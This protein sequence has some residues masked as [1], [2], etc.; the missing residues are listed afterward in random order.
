[1]NRENRAVR[2]LSLFRMLGATA[3]AMAAGVLAVATGTGGRS[4]VELQPGDRAPDFELQGS[5]G[6]VYR[7][8]GIVGPQGTGHAVVIAWFP[9]AFT[10]G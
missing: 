3:A 4:D 6:R 8:S 1:M 9:K 7:L 2:L 5:D 10:G